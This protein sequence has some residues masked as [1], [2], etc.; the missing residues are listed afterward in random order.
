MG[1][2]EATFITFLLG[3]T[4]VAAA[5]T[6]PTIESSRTAKQAA[7]PGKAAKPPAKPAPAAAQAEQP[8][9]GGGGN[10]DEDGAA[11]GAKPTLPLHV[12]GPKRVELGGGAAVDLPEGL[13]LFERAQ[14][15]ELSRQMG[16][17]PESVV[18]IIGKPASD[19]LVVIHLDEAGFIDDSDADE[20]DADDL[21]ESLRQGT[22]E[23]N[24]QRKTMGVPE[25]F[26]DGW[27]EKPR[28]VRAQHHLVWGLAAHSVNNKVINF[29]T[30]ILGRNGY[31]SVNLVAEPEKLEAAKQEALAILHATQ[32]K[33]GFRFED[34]VS[35]DHSSGIGLR[36]L[37]LGGAGVAVASKLGFLAK[38]LFALKKAIL[39]V[40]LGVGAVFRR[41]FRRGSGASDGP[42]V[43]SR[44][45][46]AAPPVPPA[47]VEPQAP[48]AE[49]LASPAAPPAEDP[50]SGGSPPG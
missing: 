7:D 23:Q 15:Q 20:L 13:L 45:R 40:V 14:A 2:R 11:Q 28:Y 1:L 41:L 30:R 25:L 46:F 39:F 50:Q 33:P 5:E 21:L 32:F 27:S 12:V 10:T 31:L 37:V 4:S 22:A 42:A 48:S 38:V 9:P 35:S 19:W 43:A 6:R 44:A 3:T 8:D 16:N 18:A 26:V 36:G 34:H 17:S 49:P 24:K 29:L 47:P